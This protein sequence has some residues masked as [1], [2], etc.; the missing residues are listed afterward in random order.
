MWRRLEC[1]SA[2]LPENIQSSQDLGLPLGNASNLI[3]SK[4][5]VHLG[6]A[7]FTI[8]L[9]LKE[10]VE[11]GRLVYVWDAIGDWPQ[12]N[13]ALHVSTREYGWSFFSPTDSADLSVLRSLVL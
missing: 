11:P 5:E 3:V 12:E 2:I 1:E 7:S 9:A 6:D 13:T 4:R 8:R 10:F